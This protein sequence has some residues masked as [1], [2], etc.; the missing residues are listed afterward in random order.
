MAEAFCQDVQLPLIIADLSNLLHTEIHFEH[1]LRLL[2]REALLQPTAIYLEHFDQLLTDDPKHQYYQQIIVKTSAEYFLVTFFAR[3]KSWNPPAHV[4]QHIFIPIEFSLPAYPLR[5][6]LWEVFWDDHYPVSPEVKSETLANAFRLTGGQIRNAV[7]GARNI[8]VAR[9]NNGN[10]CITLDDL[11]RSC[12][13][14]SNQKLAELAQKIMPHYTWDDIIL[15]VDKLQQL[16]EICNYVKYRQVVYDD[17]GFDRKLSLGKGLNVLFSGP[18]GTGKTMAAEIIAHELKL[19]LYKIDLSSVVSK[20]IGETEK[21]LAKIFKEAETSNAI[22]FFDEADALFGKRSEVKDAHDRYANIE[23]GYLLQKMEE[24]TGVVILATNLQK[25]MDEA[26]V[27]RMHFT[28]EFPFPEEMYRLQIW[29]HIFPK[30]TPLEETVDFKFMAR[31]FKVPGGNIKNIALAA[32]FY[33]ADDGKIV[34]M[35][36][37]I[38]ATKREYQKM[39]RLCDRSDFGEYYELIQPDLK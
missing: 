3:E 5:K 24:Y 39:G 29:Q 2:F 9:Q 12:R 38:Q 1:A 25:N 36:H 4:N 6:Q 34:T 15:P 13:N 14:Q 19:D 30:E 28:V 27:R 17:W 22:L 26:F 23:I 32:A 37:L 35:A 21:N 31:K 33:A 11:H 8:A 7:A 20:Y 10:S 18:S 16:R